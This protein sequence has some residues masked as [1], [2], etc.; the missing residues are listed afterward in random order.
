MV[1]GARL[2]AKW[3]PNRWLNNTAAPFIFPFECDGTVFTVFPKDQ[4][5]GDGAATVSTT[6]SRHGTDIVLTIQCR[7][8]GGKGLTTE[9][10]V[11]VLNVMKQFP[12]FGIIDLGIVKD[13][14]FTGDGCG[15]VT[16]IDNMCKADGSR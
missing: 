14:V 12:Y 5:S 3:G 1:S 13:L 6:Q 9:T 4:E 7:V 16:Y 15:D 11:L 8:T 10:P 2:T